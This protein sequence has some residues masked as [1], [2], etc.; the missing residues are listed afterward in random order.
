[1]AAEE[2][3]RNVQNIHAYKQSCRSRLVFS[4]L[5]WDISIKDMNYLTLIHCRAVRKPLK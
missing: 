5:Q 4:V 1:M 3:K 2:M